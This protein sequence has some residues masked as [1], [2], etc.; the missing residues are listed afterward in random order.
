LLAY[1]VL[2]LFSHASLSFFFLKKLKKG[3]AMKR[4][5]GKRKRGIRN[6][7]KIER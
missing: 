6:T 4:E 1:F 7:K 5:K 3:A 2:F